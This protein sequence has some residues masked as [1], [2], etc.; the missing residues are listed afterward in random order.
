M[1]DRELFELIR[2]LC[3][4]LGNFQLNPL[5]GKVREGPRLV[6][7]GHFFSLLSRRTEV[8]V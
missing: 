7:R 2:F 1:W 5:G 3:V 8:I 4:D 6:G